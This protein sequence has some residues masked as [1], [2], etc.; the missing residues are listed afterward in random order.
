MSHVYYTT[1][2]EKEFIRGL[3]TY[4]SE[5]TQTARAV[6][7]ITRIKLLEGY[8]AS[9]Q[10]RRSWEHIN[11]EKVEAFA[12]REIEKCCEKKEG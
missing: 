1:E 9:C 8:L 7:N 5:S 2:Q 11:K 6:L 3:G 4:G 12:A 10:L